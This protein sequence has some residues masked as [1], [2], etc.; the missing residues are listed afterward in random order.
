MDGPGSLRCLNCSAP[1]ASGEAKFF[2]EVLVCQSCY[3]V[4]E[5]VFERGAMLLRRM[6]ILLRDTIKWTLTRGKLSFAVGDADKISDLELLKRIV[7]LYGDQTQCQTPTT[8][9]SIST[10][11]DVQ[12]AGSS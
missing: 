9:S 10:K 4:A 7:G 3:A 6:A 8:L 11:P 12:D 1:V 2:A 5:R